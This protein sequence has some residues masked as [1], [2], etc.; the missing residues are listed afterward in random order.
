MKTILLFWFT[1]I[2]LVS[3]ATAATIVYDGCTRGSGKSKTE[4]RELGTFSQIHASGVYQINIRAGHDTQV[5]TIQGDDN[6]LP[7]IK[8]GVKGDLLEIFTDKA[9]CPTLDVVIDIQVK[10][11]DKVIAAGSDDYIIKGLDNREF[12][13]SLSGTGNIEVMGKTGTFFLDLSGSGDVI[14]REL[15]AET[16]DVNIEGTGNATVFASEQLKAEIGGVADVH[17][18]GNPK[19]VVQEIYGVGT[20]Y[21][22]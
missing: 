1:L 22:E 13:L 4:T 6:I 17:Y 7:F 21:K 5:F 19:E 9:I 15:K 11:L 12:A 14:A 8:T 2:C 18:F 20:L 10:N 16:V 3:S